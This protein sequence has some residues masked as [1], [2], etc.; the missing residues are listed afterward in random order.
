M[1]LPGPGSDLNSRHG[2]ETAPTLRTSKRGLQRTDI[3]FADYPGRTAHR[4]ALQNTFRSW[5]S[6]YGVDPR[7]QIVLARHA[8]R[9]V[10][11]RHYQSFSVLDLWAKISRLPPIRTAAAAT[12]VA[13]VT[14]TD[15]AKS[16][17]RRVAIDDVRRRLKLAA[18]GRVE[19]ETGRSEGE[20]IPLQEQEFTEREA[21]FADVAQLVR[22]PACGAGCRWFESS[23]R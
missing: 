11:L 1:E 16:V 5:P 6:P 22:A 19:A 4:H 17:V 13:R 14:G 3:P 18:G 8:Q 12:Q 9:R 23:R 15:Y 7:G 2:F 21:R 10:P 20:H